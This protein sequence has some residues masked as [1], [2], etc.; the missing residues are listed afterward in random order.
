M[1]FGGYVCRCLS[2]GAE[3]SS[4]A[5]MQYT[6]RVSRRSYSRSPCSSGS[7]CLNPTRTRKTSRC[8][9]CSLQVLECHSSGC[10]R[11]W[12]EGEN[13]LCRLVAASGNWKQHLRRKLFFLN[14]FFCTGLGPYFVM[15]TT[16]KHT[17]V[18]KLCKSGK[19]PQPCKKRIQVI[20]TTGQGNHPYN[21]AILQLL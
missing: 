1:H 3:W 2:E 8:C 17:Q 4:V 14:F 9:C 13:A 11:E 18:Y 12:L 20:R 10:Q 19:D 16:C 6:S 7:I 21:L 15:S 5:R